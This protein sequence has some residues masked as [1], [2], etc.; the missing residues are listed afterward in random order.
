MNNKKDNLFS[1]LK[2]VITTVFLV[3]NVIAGQLFG[4]FGRTSGFVLLTFVVLSA[5]VFLFENWFK[6]SVTLT[7]YH[8]YM[9]VFA[10]FCTLS[11]LWAQDS[12]LS[13]LKGERILDIAISMSIFYMIYSERHK[14][15]VNTLFTI[16]MWSGYLIVAYEIYFYG[17]SQLMLLLSETV[18]IHSDFLNA[19]TLG[20]VVAY[21]IVINYYLI[22]YRKTPFWQSFPLPFALIVL[23]GSGSRK[24]ITIVLLGVVLITFFKNFRGG[25]LFRKFPK[26][27]ISG[28]VLLLAF[29]FLSGLA[30]FEGVMERLESMLNIFNGNASID[31]STWE[32]L[33]LIK[34]GWK[35][36]QE[37]PILGVGMDN[38]RIFSW[39]VVSK[40]LYLHNNYMEILSGGGLI[41]FIV[42]YWFYGYLFYA[43]FKY[44]KGN[45]ELC[46]I[47]ITLLIIR[48]IIDFGAVSYY[49]QDTY[50]WLL[51]FYLG[52]KEL[53]S[54][55]NEVMYDR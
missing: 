27:L 1:Y 25:K 10:A 39:I 34:L 35:L 29:Q 20:M 28:I 11:S 2:Y 21:S 54:R 43:Y 50:F 22:L 17:W 3:L 45:T 30:M 24:A 36:F 7:I 4:G 53:K 40:V 49:D 5:V 32:R 41:G 47:C 13:T 48:L 26:I 16:M 44:R 8:I 15:I 6:I 18:R 12:S 33:E 38:P 31:K 14:D 23:A 55:W 19:N 51:I 46:G 52:A 9:L 37:N 42:Y